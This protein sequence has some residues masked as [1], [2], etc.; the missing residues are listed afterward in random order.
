M[1]TKA[2]EEWGNGKL[3]RVT[4]T[5]SKRRQDYQVLNWDG[6]P[7]PIVHQFDRHKPLTNYFYKVKGAEYEEEWRKKHGQLVLQS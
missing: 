5:Q 6:T 4:T 3:V 2:L 7:S 1:R